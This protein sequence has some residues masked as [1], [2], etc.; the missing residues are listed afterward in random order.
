MMTRADLETIAVRW[1]RAGWQQGDTA[2]VRAMYAE[3]F[4]DLSS[5]AAQRGTRDDNL[6]GIVELY[7]AFP[8][9]YATIEIWSS[10]PI[11][12]RS[13]YGGP[14]Q[15]RTTGPTSGSH[16]PASTSGFAGSRPCG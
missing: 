14:R 7:A 11:R 12:A 1:V 16:P 9:I 13:R 10:I 3:D 5:P 2:T 8:D 6:A 15:A 4:V